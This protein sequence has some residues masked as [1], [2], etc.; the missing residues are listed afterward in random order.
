MDTKR[1]IAAFVAV[2]SLGLT[3]GVVGAQSTGTKT[4]MSFDQTF[5]MKAAQAGMA[6]VEEG[7]IAVKKGMIQGVKDFGQ[8][9]IDDHSKAN[10]E[11]KTLTQSKSI[12]LPSEPTTQQK[13]SVNRLDKLSG[14]EFD[15][16]YVKGAKAD[17]LQAIKLFEDEV[18]KGNDP[19]LKAF[20]SKTLPTIREHYKMLLNMK[21]GTKRSSTKM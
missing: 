6:E 7:Q 10:D 14:A 8:K 5:V 3:G 2:G 15:S 9:M 11:L 13:A 20:A 19:D 4:K 21:L 12:T 17:H 1:T 18:K 16:T